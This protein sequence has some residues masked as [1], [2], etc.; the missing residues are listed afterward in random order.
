MVSGRA[1]RSRSQLPGVAIPRFFRGAA[2]VC[3]A[4]L[5]VAADSPATNPRKPNLLFILTDE[6]AARSMKVYGNHKVQ[7]PH[8]NRLADES[9]VFR[10]AYVT[11]PVCTPARSSILTGL[12]PTQNTM[13][14]NGFILPATA[15][16]F[17]ELVNDP[18]YRTGYHGKW[19]LGDEQF[20]QH[21]FQEWVSMEE[22]QDNS[23][24]RAKGTRSAYWHFLKNLGYTPDTG[25]G[26]FSREFAARLPIEHCKPA[27]LEQKAIDFLRRHKASPFILYVSFLEPHMPYTGPLNGLYD[28][29]D[30]DLPPNFHDP[31]DD[32]EPKAYRNARQKGLTQPMYG[33]PL[34]TEE[35]WRRLIANYWGLITQVDRSV[36]AILGALETLGLADNTIV[37]F[38]SDHGDMMGAHRLIAKDVMYEESAKVPWLIRAP[39]RGRTQ[40]IVEQPVSHID[41]VPT[42]LELMHAKSNQKLPGKSL[43]PL[44]ES[45]P[46]AEDHVFIQ[47]NGFNRADGPNRT[48]AVAPGGPQSV[49]DLYARA[50]VSPDGWKLNLTDC[51]RHQLFDLKRDPHE[52]TNLYYSG[53]HQ[54]V[55]ARLRSKIRDWQ[56]ATG[57]RVVLK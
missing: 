30:V 45:K 53:R 19:H 51:D 9:I 41:L 44:T 3:L 32:D 12:W 16:C 23:P 34:R 47:W 43:L 25:N 1:T 7:T 20:A 50:V 18:E 31:I 46:V 52:T 38:T 54:D 29:R 22:Y 2:L 49:Q 57:D 40:R 56:A 37:V 6:Q 17:P 5:G 11:Q 35:Q 10:H 39:Q 33:F 28:P 14:K 21:G 8:L 36:G 4:G 15:K 27:F 26:L 48:K 24:T 42:L 55:I 13:V